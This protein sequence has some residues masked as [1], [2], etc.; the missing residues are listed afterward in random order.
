MHLTGNEYFNSKKIISHV[1]R[2]SLMSLDKSDFYHVLVYW[3]PWFPFK[4]LIYTFKEFIIFFPSNIQMYFNSIIK[5]F[6]KCPYIDIKEISENGVVILF[7]QIC[8]FKLCIDLLYE[9]QGKEKHVDKITRN[10]TLRKKT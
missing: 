5:S 6:L 9:R 1:K 8:T 2:T 10:P 7:T 3:M 4:F